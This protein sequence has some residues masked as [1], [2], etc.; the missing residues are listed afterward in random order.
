PHAAQHVDR[1]GEWQADFDETGYELSCMGL[2]DRCWLKY[3]G[4]LWQDWTEFVLADLGIYRY[5]SVEF[6]SDSRSLC[7]VA[8]VDTYRHQ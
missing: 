3:F 7:L 1:F 2:C 6:S 4:N 8:D 5:G